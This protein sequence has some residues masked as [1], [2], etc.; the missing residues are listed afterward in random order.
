MML[1]MFIGVLTL[2]RRLESLVA[3]AMPPMGRMKTL[4][5]RV[6]MS[7]KGSWGAPTVEVAPVS[8]TADAMVLFMMPCLNVVVDMEGPVDCWLCV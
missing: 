4:V 5:E 6:V 8:L 1:T 3:V 7:S 2:R